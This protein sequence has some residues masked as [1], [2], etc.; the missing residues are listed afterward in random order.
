MRVL[1]WCSGWSSAMMTTSSSANPSRSAGAYSNTATRAGRTHAS[2]AAVA[3][4][5]R[6]SDAGSGGARGDRERGGP[7]PA[8]QRLP[9]GPG[10]GVG[11]G[12]GGGGMGGGGG[13]ARRAQRSRAR[14][15]TLSRLTRDSGGGHRGAAASPA[16]GAVEGGATRATAGPRTR[17]RT[18]HDS[19]RES[20]EGG[21]YLKAMRI[22][23]IAIIAHVDHGKTTLV[24]KMLR[25]AGA[26]RANQQVAERALDSNELERER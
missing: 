23:N 7:S 3:P 9:R 25:Q 17:G 10:F 11:G 26:F 20:G 1:R 22:R 15:K 14:R 18:R 5:A 21:L 6:S 13:G 19:R 8:L 12:G 16:L 2:L 24:D 4:G